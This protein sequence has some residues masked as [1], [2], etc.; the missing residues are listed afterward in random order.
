[1]AERLSCFET[2][3]RDNLILEKLRGYAEGCERIGLNLACVV[4]CVIKQG[5]L[6]T[7]L[8]P[9][10]GAVPIFFIIFTSLPL[11]V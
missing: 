11:F 5:K 4:E 8:I 6:P 9:S 7:I 2:D 3:Q 10:R 1:M